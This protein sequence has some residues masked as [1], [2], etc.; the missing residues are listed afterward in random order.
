[1]NVEEIKTTQDVYT[2]IDENIKYGWIDYN[3]EKHKKQ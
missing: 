1:M 2:F 3:G